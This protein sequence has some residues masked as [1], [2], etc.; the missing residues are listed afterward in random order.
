MS[1]RTKRTAGL[2][3][4]QVT[5][6]GLRR[7][8]LVC[9]IRIP[10]EVL[11]AHAARFLGAELWLVYGSFEAYLDRNV[12]APIPECSPLPPEALKTR[13]KRFAIWVSGASLSGMVWV[14]RCLACRAREIRPFED[15]P[16]S[17]GSCGGRHVMSIGVTAEHVACEDHAKRGQW[18]CLCLP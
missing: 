4:P 12:G 6:L 9:P 17:C 2:G 16:E 13:A 11:E 14:G 15:R 18:T 7:P 1:P 10:D 8:P 3:P 5:V